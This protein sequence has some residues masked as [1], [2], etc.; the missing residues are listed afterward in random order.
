MTYERD[1]KKKAYGPYAPMIGSNS[2]PVDGWI[3]FVLDKGPKPNTSRLRLR[4]YR[5]QLWY[6]KNR[7]PR[8]GYDFVGIGRRAGFIMTFVGLAIPYVGPLISAVS[9]AGAGAVC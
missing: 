1:G 4:K 6:P 9:L 8:L 7:L 5:W 2:F 3:R